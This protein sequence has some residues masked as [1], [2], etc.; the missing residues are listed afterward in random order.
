LELSLVSGVDTSN[1]SRRY[2]TARLK[3]KTDRKLAYAKGRTESLYLAKI[4]ESQT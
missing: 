3:L 2:D 1:V 4:V